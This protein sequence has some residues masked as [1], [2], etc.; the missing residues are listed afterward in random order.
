MTSNEKKLKELGAV[1]DKNNSLRISQAI[2]ALRNETPFPGALALL[3]SHYDRSTSI[4][5]RQLIS[6]FMNDM[7]DKSLCGEVVAEIKKDH[8]KDT[9]QMIASSCWQS[10]LDYSDYCLDFADL[11]LV[12]DY[13]TALECFTVIESSVH[14]LSGEDKRVITDRIRKGAVS[15]VDERSALTA[16]LIA[17]LK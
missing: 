12:S 15:I 7:K 9:L 10:G 3:I 16:E 11:F 2:R 5:V 1:L 17:V 4:T 14:E 6:E 13:M 8:K